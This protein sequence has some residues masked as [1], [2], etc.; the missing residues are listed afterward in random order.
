LRKSGF[1]TQEDFD[2]HR[3]KPWQ[4]VHG[5]A[6]HLRG[7]VPAVR[8]GVGPHTHLKVDITDTPWVWA[9]V[10]KAGSNLTDL[11]TRQHVG[12]TNITSD[13]HHPQLHAAEHEVGGGD[14]LAFADIT[15]FGTYIDQALLQASSPIHATVKLTALTDGY[16]PYH[17]DDAT[18]LANSPI[19]TDGADVGINT[20]LP[21]AELNL[22]AGP[23]QVGMQA[24][25]IWAS[26]GANDFL[27]NRAGVSYIKQ[28]VVGGHIRFVVSDA[29]PNDVDALQINDDGSINFYANDLTTTGIMKAS[30]FHLTAGVTPN[31]A[32]LSAVTLG[33]LEE[34][35]PIRYDQTTAKFID[36]WGIDYDNPRLVYKI[37]TDFF[38]RADDSNDPWD[39]AGF[40]GGGC[41]AVAGEKNHPGIVRLSSDITDAGYRFMTAINCILI[42]G[43]EHS[44]FCFKTGASLVNFRARLGYQDSLTAA[45][46]TDGVFIDIT[47]ATLTGKTYNNTAN[48]TT[49]TNYGLAVDTWYRGKIAVLANQALTLLLA[50]YT[51]CVAGDVGKQVQV[52]GEE[53]GLLDSYDNVTRIWRVSTG[54]LIPTGSAIT[55]TGGTGAGTSSVDS[56]TTI[57]NVTF[58]LYTLVAGEQT[59][60]WTNTLTTNIPMTAGRETGHGVVMWVAANIMRTFDLDM[61]IATRAGYITR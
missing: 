34:G 48:S 17:V 20:V 30:T 18:G 57:K 22:E 15:G 16:V 58:A 53:F 19:F 31:L 21:E 52:A 41:V 54:R 14:L 38:S 6:R 43:A 3:E 13:Q 51:N 11:A 37:Y 61:M 45:A 1:V 10:N 40:G 27:F 55:I 29:A 7:V 8:G 49:G 26:L 12:L 56:V 25:A 50:G 36:S 32:W 47:G 24:D 9:D 33:T 35:E 44:E 46:P 59:I 42:A 28:Q 2:A 5:I 39:G 4:V 60:V 23:L